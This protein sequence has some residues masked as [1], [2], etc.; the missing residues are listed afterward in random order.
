[1]DAGW[2]AT[3]PTTDSPQH[4]QSEPRLCASLLRLYQV[5][6]SHPVCFPFLFSLQHPLFSSL[7]SRENSVE[8]VKF[9]ALSR[10]EAG[11]GPNQPNFRPNR[12]NAG[13]FA[14][15]PCIPGNYP[16]TAWVFCRFPQFCLRFCPR[17]ALR[18]R[19]T[20]EFPEWSTKHPLF[21]L[22][23][24]GNAKCWGP[25]VFLFV[26]RKSLCR[27]TPAAAAAG[28]RRQQRR[29]RRVFC[30]AARPENRLR[31]RGSEL[32]GPGGRS[33]PAIGRYR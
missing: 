12:Q 28:R 31:G 26:C 10:V 20:R 24:S 5:F 15:N 30:F 18:L 33:V 23:I 22:E 1:M 8:I 29:L 9:W 19:E 2:T 11:L 16:A 14:E 25:S 27:P 17:P 7:F 21:S 4:L 32:R 6:L 13:N 3:P